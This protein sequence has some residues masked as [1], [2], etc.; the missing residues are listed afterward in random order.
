M[1]EAAAALEED[2]TAVANS[3]E[4]VVASAE[5]ETAAVSKSEAAAALEEDE[6]AVANSS[7]QVVASAEAETAAVSKSDLVAA[8]PLEQYFELEMAVASRT[9]AVAMPVQ[10]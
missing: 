8:L 5:A 1:S 3:S 2:E 9:E 7:E 4:Q 6:T 10:H